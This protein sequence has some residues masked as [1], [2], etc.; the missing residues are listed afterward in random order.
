[1]VHFIQKIVYIPLTTI[2]NFGFVQ[3]LGYV[4]KSKP[5]PLFLQLTFKKSLKNL[6]HLQLL[7]N[8]Q[9][10]LVLSYLY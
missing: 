2:E 1:M 10:F 9:N 6:L 3:P 7:P 5:Y 8:L 4:F